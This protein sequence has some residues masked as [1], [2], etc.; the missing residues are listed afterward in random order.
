MNDA[1]RRVL[2]LAVLGMVFV[3]MLIHYGATIE[4]DRSLSEPSDV[5]QN[6]EAHAGDSVYLWARVIETG[7]ESTTIHAGGVRLT[8]T[9]AVAT[10]DPGDVIQVAGTARPDHRI[11]AHRTVVAKAAGQRYMYG[12]SAIAAVLTAGL[13]VHHW[14][15]ATASLSLERREAED[16]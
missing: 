11:D 13:F 9:S 15:I 4:R 6:W 10:A 3:G 16:A 7:P 14:R 5:L 12:I 8:V 1:R 2:L